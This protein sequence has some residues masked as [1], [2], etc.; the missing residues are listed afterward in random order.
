MVVL[1]TLVWA[2]LWP[3]LGEEDRPPTRWRGRLAIGLLVGLNAGFLHWA[4][5]YWY[6]EINRAVIWGERQ[7]F[8]GNISRA[9]A[10]ALPTNLGETIVALRNS[11]FNEGSYTVG[12]VHYRRRVPE[13]GKASEKQRRVIR[14][15]NEQLDEYDATSL[16]PFTKLIPRIVYPPAEV[17]I[18]L[19]VKK[20]GSMAVYARRNMPGL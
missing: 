1:A 7:G 13:P 19:M 2:M 15:W 14:S 3:L 6:G 17:T 11:G 16:R 10:K 5:S 4:R 8:D 12:A 20:D 9:I 18:Y